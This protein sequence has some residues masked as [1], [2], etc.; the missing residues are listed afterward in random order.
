K[1][2]V[3]KTTPEQTLRVKR[4]DRSS[5]CS[6]LISLPGE[7]VLFLLLAALLFPTGEAG[8][9][10]EGQE[11]KPHSHPYMAY[12]QFKT[13][14]E[15]HI[16]GGFLVR[17]DFVLT[18]AHCLGRAQSHSAPGP[19]VTSTPPQ[20]LPCPG[21]SCLSQLLGCISCD[22]M[23]PTP[24]QCPQC[25][26]MNVTLRAHNIKQQERTQQVIQVRRAIRHPDYNP[27]NFSNDIISLPSQDLLPFPP[28]HP[29]HLTSPCGS[30]EGRH[31]NVTALS[32][33]R[34]HRL[35]QTLASS[36]SWRERPSRL[37]AVRQ[38]CLPRAMACMKP[39]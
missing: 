26:S 3:I 14:G 17:E 9:I 25:S 37:A 11:A 30:G 7:M 5:S 24:L 2:Q 19:S 15:P 39:G 8:K 32:R 4:P 10:I 6:D 18:A 34:D 20:L 22:P 38:L 27:K 28:Y 21:V 23:I 31:I 29:G 33:L 35:S 13:S 1:S 36:H 16:C 12:L